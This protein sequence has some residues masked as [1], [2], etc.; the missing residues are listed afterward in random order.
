MQFW[1]FTALAALDA[2]VR[3]EGEMLVHAQIPTTRF[4]HCDHRQAWQQIQRLT[5]TCSADKH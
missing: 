2:G 3:P 1:V 5:L 4:E